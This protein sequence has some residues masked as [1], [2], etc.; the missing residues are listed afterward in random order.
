MRTDRYI[1]NPVGWSIDASF[2][3]TSIEPIHILH[4]LHAWW[5]FLGTYMRCWSEVNQI[6]YRRNLHPFVGPKNFWIKINTIAWRNP[7]FEVWCIAI[8]DRIGSDLT[9]NE[10][11]GVK[12]EV[13]TIHRSV[14]CSAY[15]QVFRGAS[16]I[17]H[18]HADSSIIQSWH[19]YMQRYFRS[20]VKVA[21]SWYSKLLAM[22]HLILSRLLS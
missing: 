1:V 4:V 10:R 16:M 5:T 18:P 19:A 13:F 15:I 7:G 11:W 9:F 12:F 21:R 8:C 6:V 20:R 14:D 17:Q 3:Y 2:T 22:L